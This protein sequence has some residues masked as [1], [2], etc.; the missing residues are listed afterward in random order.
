VKKLACILLAAALSVFAVMNGTRG[1]TQSLCANITTM[2]QTL[3]EAGEKSIVSYLDA[4]VV[5]VIFGNPKTGLWTLVGVD[6]SGS[7]CT[8]RNGKGLVV[9]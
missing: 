9:S 4:G 5:K 8:M 2:R 1:Y 6:P 3:A 7:A